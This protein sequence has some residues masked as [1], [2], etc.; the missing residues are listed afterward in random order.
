MSSV[1][2]GFYSGVF[3]PSDSPLYDPTGGGEY[4]NGDCF[5][6]VGQP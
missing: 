6:T 3:Y 4:Q 2:G 1:V 5:A